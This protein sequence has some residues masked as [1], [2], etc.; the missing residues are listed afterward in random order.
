[1]QTPVLWHTGYDQTISITEWNLQIRTL[2]HKKGQVP[3]P[4]HLHFPR[5]VPIII[6]YERYN[7]LLGYCDC[8]MGKLKEGIQSIDDSS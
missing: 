4:P 8:V 2:E 1:M 6:I 7:T 5:E 3:P